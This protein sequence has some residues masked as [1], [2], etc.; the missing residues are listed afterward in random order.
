M[1]WE[2]LSTPFL[3]SSGIPLQSKNHTLC[4]LFEYGIILA[5]CLL[6]ASEKYGRGSAVIWPFNITSSGVL[7]KNAMNVDTF[8]HMQRELVDSF[9]ADEIHAAGAGKRITRD[10]S[11]KKLVKFLDNLV[12]SLP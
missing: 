8:R 12:I 10:R 9:S 3:N 2:K 4:L 1:E 6:Q 5:S 11:Q 7:L